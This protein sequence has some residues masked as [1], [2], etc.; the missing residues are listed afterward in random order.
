MVTVYGGK[1]LRS[2]EISL[3]SA[4]LMSSVS[5][6]ETVKF[7][8]LHA[9]WWNPDE[10]PLIHMNSIRVQ[11]IR[12][13]VALNRSRLNKSTTENDHPKKN[14]FDIPIY[15]HRPFNDLK[16]LDIGCGGGLL[17]ES[18][19]RLGAQEVTGLDPSEN[20]L[21]VARNRSEALLL[22]PRKSK[23]DYES[24]TAEEWAVRRPQ[25]Y[26]VACILDVIE[27]IENLD[28]LLD[29][30]SSLVK[31]GGLLIV[32]TLN[33]T[34]ISYFMSIVGA[35]YLMGYVPVGTHD[36]A[37]YRSPEEVQSLVHKFSFVPINVSGMTLRTPP[38]C[39]WNW[40]LDPN[41]TD[42]NWI[43]TYQLSQQEQRNN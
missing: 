20:L 18:L 3:L 16:M 6:S 12:Q 1:P 31:P 30:A 29:A 36:W 28:S 8:A 39:G 21:Q 11:Y 25:H 38:M 34:T 7:N 42:I 17:S 26:D 27:H 19:V 5:L 37:L 4:R 15:P 41:K 14:M 2:R 40:S 24:T 10:N 23:P 22:D 32:S 43:A 13:Q 33:R 9:G 35:E